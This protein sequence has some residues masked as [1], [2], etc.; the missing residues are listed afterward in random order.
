M[1]ERIDTVRGDWDEDGLH[2]FV[3][4]DDDE[5]DLRITDVETARD[6]IGIADGLRGWVNEHDRQ[7]AAY[8]AAT[9][10][11]RA[12]VLRPESAPE[13][14]GEAERAAADTERKRRRENP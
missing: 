5:H 7:R 10:E 4:T 14:P 1:S 11:E 6:L 2:L 12:A 9:P 13:P 3:S 8:D